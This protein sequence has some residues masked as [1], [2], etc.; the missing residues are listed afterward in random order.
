MARSSAV[1]RCI[2]STDSYSK[3]RHEEPDFDHG[4]KKSRKDSETEQ[5]LALVEK[6]VAEE[7]KRSEKKNSQNL[8]AMSK[9]IQRQAND[10][11]TAQQNGAMDLTKKICSKEKAKQ[12]Y[13]I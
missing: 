11:E 10:A 8:K 9:I 13:T 2:G 4:C 7:L 1:N 5:R 3:G 6:K 12:V